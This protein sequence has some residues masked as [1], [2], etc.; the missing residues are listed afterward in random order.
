[1]IEENVKPQ[2]VY[3]G[4]QAEEELFHI[5]SDNMQTLR[6][7]PREVRKEVSENVNKYIEQVGRDYPE[8]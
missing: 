5:S 4:K 1:M 8:K 6:R 3:Y 7:L 2:E